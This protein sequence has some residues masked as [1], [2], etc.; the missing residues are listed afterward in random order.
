MTRRGSAYLARLEGGG[1]ANLTI[2]PHLQEAVER[3]FSA[4]DVPYG[5]AAVVGVRDG[6][7]LAL[8]GHSREDASLGP[9]EL[10]LR[11]WAPS[12]SV[13]KIVTAATL[14]EH[15]GVSAGSRVCYHGGVSAVLDSNLLDLPALDRTCGSLAFGL[16]KSQNA[17]FAKLAIRHLDGETLGRTASAFGFGESLPFAAELQASVVSIPET[18]LEFARASAGFWHSSLSVLHGALLAAS[19]ANDGVMPMPR[20]I[21]RAVGSDGTA[22]V[23]P[24]A[25]QRRV[26][27]PATAREVAQMMILTTRNGTARSAFHDRRGRPLLPV[28]VAGKTGSLSFRGQEGDPSLPVAVAPNAYLG[29]SW[30]VGF[31]PAQQPRLAFAILVGN[32][33]IWR[34]KAPYVAKILVAADLAQQGDTRVARVLALR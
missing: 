10:A 30:F 27:S 29:Y 19:I 1:E 7:V 23:E 3:V 9:S 21:E 31:A 20:L 6:R 18:P 32:R 11:P 13:F 2:K 16:A 34:I 12:A 22:I 28:E 15:A 17:I 8:V 5:A 4:F 26:V 24:R 25:P 14:I 33:A